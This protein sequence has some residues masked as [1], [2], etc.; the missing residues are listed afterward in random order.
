[1]FFMGK[2]EIEGGVDQNS[3]EMQSMTE[4]EKVKIQK[5]GLHFKKILSL[6]SYKIHERFQNLLSAFRYM[7]G[8]HQLSLSLNEFA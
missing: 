2:T 5:Q 4:D 8:D 3:S 7:D 1:M 6:I